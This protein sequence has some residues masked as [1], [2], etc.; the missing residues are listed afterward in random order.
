MTRPLADALNR[1]LDHF[2][3]AC[4][5][6]FRE[7]ARRAQRGERPLACFDAD[8][9]IWAEDIGEGM[10]RWLAA[11]GL[12]PGTRAPWTEVWEEYEARVRADRCAGYAWAVAVME[13]LREAD[14][15]RWS[16]QF[17]A[18]WPNYRRPMVDL[19]RGLQE[20]G[21]DVWIVS[22]TNRWLVQAAAR[23]MGLIPERVLGIETRVR[24]GELTGEVVHPVTCRAGKVEAIRQRLGRMPDLA[25]GDSVGDLEMMEAASHVVVV[26]RRDHPRAEMVLLARE[27]GWPVQWF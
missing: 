20:G 19:L 16:E 4:R 26:G 11:G 8:G 2:H 27:R 21:V 3:P 10:L 7:V 12:L 17:A 23:Q 22:A 14:V 6:V 18:A 24:D 15:I 9:T 25:V 5:R 13:G 1:A